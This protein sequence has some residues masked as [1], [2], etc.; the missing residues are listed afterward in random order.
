MDKTTDIHAKNNDP[1]V[2]RLVEK[3]PTFNSAYGLWIFSYRKY[4]AA[5][6]RQSIVPRYFNFYGLSHLIKR[7][8][9]WYWQRDMGY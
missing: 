2:H 4:A 7:G 8:G 3:V 1:V 9:G 6:K 5:P